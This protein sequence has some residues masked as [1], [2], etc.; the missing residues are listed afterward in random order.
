MTGHL[1]MNIPLRA[2][3]QNRKAG[4]T[5]LNYRT[6]AYN[7]RLDKPYHGEGHVRWVEDTTRAGLRWVGYADEAAKDI[8][9]RLNHT[10]WYA[11]SFQDRTYRGVIY[12]LPSRAKAE[13]DSTGRFVYGYEDPDNG[14]NAALLSFDACDNLRDAVK[15]ADG[16]AER[17]AKEDREH[18]EAW[19]EAR[20]Y[21]ELGE[22]VK[23]ERADILAMLKEARPLRKAGTMDTPAICRT[24]Q[25]A[26]KA[27]LAR[28]ERARAKR[29]ELLDNWGR[30][31]GWAA[32]I[33][34]NG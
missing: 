21:C 14:R 17:C 32:G 27:A 18:D 15:W 5:Y 13:D 1:N 4:K 11:D 20:R 19:Q 10:G 3:L 6:G 30:S 28:I 33:A 7:P 23:S 24:L 34:D 9:W 12:R 8:G 2:R 25:G 31:P 26:V 22:E 16:F 29:A